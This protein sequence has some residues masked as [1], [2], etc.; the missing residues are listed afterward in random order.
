MNWGTIFKMKWL[1]VF[2]PLIELFVT[3]SLAYFW[4]DDYKEIAPIIILQFV[5]YTVL[6]TPILLWGFVIR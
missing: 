5:L 6:I 1:I 2:S 4:S 3:A